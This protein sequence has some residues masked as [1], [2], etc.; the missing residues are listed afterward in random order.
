VRAFVT[1]G[2]G[3]V[4]G[5]LRQHLEAC[6]DTVIAPDLDE[7]DVLDSQAVSEA[8]FSA[9]P[10]VVYHLAAL[11]NV[12]ESW[13]QPRLTYEVN[14]M[15]THTV[16]DGA[17]RFAA[18]Q[19][20]RVVLISSAEVYGRVGP[21][22]VPIRESLPPKPVTPYAASKAASEMLGIQAHQGYG[23]PVIITRAFNHVGPS[24]TASFV[25]SALAR[26]IIEAQRN[27]STSLSVGNLTP[28]RDFTDVRDVVRAYRLLAESGQPGGTYNVCSGHAVS[29]AELANRMLELANV[30]LDLVPDPDLQ[31]PVDIP[32]L[33]GDP[34]KL[35]SHT[36]WE[37]VH[38]LDETLAD[39]LQFWRVSLAAERT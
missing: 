34:S 16:L 7:L 38:Q 3:F 4:G 8:L 31:R 24:Q 14:V 20:P 18:K 26:R 11:T 30:K 13:E 10:D 36:G 6:G 21:E 12:A 33:C 35:Q 19:M 25:V 9:R 2:H 37:R 1:C 23:V 39:T 28:K 22:H 27:A 32:V 5:W 17:R 29:I 15:G